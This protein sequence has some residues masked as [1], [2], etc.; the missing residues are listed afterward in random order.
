MGKAA[1]S[2]FE[3]FF[4]RPISLILIMLTVVS[5]AWPYIR[6]LVTGTKRYAKR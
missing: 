6:K 3:V 4:T 5:A 2:L 1:G